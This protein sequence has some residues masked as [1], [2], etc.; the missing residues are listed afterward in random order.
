FPVAI[1]V[2]TLA[3]AAITLVMTV[4]GGGAAGYIE[5]KLGKPGKRGAFNKRRSGSIVAGILSLL[6]ALAFGGGA[7]GLV[8]LVT[9][10]IAVP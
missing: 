10:G 4:L 3:G 6:V 9:G 7:A 2:Q 5:L 8:F 1:G